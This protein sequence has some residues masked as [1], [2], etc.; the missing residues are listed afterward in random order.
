MHFPCFLSVFF[1]LQAPWFFHVFVEKSV[2]LTNSS[3]LKAHWRT[4]LSL[5]FGSFFE[6]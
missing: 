3:Q 5:I 6:S 1:E 4:R 2:C